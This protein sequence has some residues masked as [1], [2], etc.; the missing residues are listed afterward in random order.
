MQKESL[1]MA[2]KRDFSHCMLWCLN[3]R[4]HWDELEWVESLWGRRQK[5][6]WQKS[7]SSSLYSSASTAELCLYDKS[8]SIRGFMR[9]TPVLIVLFKNMNVRFSIHLRSPSANS[10]PGLVCKAAV[11]WKEMCLRWGRYASVGENKWLCLISWQGCLVLALVG[12][13]WL[14]FSAM[15]R[16]YWSFTVQERKR[17]ISSPV[18]KSTI[19]FKC[20]EASG[21]ICFLHMTCLVIYS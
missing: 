20:A 14:Y 9:K 10:F 19:E 18:K 8:I 13:L 1:T 15:L 21:G 6:C 12:C 3:P 5:K 4:R 17:L 7:T 11:A 16:K 2:Q